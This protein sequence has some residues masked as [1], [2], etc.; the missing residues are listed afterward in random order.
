[1]ARLTAPAG[2]GLWRLSRSHWVGETT[3]GWGWISE[4]GASKSKE[5][6]IASSSDMADDVTE[7]IAA[8]VFARHREIMSSLN[9][10]VSEYAAW[11]SWPQTTADNRSSWITMGLAN[12]IAG[13]GVEWLR[14]C[15]H[16]SPRS[17]SDSDPSQ[18]YPLDME[19]A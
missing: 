8:S 14:E 13:E 19:M 15:F 5:A 2:Y 1:M 7:A 18:H 6:N 4:S 12:G 3:T 9:R 17:S 11:S 16:S 10:V